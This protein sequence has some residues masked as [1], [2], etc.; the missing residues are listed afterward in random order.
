MVSLVGYEDFRQIHDSENSQVYRARRI[1]DRAS[2]SDRT[3]RQPVI[4]KFLNRDYPTAEQ[5]RRY[6][7]EYHL[8]CHL[9]S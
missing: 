5:I 6:K 7:Q 4:L 3:Y 2:V 8:T 1:R 9:E